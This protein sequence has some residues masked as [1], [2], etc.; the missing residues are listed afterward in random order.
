MI[1]NIAFPIIE[2]TLACLLKCLKRCWDQRC[3]TV[4]TSKTTKKGYIALYSDDIFIISERYAYLIAILIVSLT[5]SGVIP[6]LT[7]IAAISFFLLYYSDKV[8][9]F[10]FFQNP[11]NYNHTLHKL[12]PKAIVIGLVSHFALTAFFLS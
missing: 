11:I 8:L 6:I 1:F 5:F 7:P 10:K 4:V 12:I 3:C 9:M 2:L